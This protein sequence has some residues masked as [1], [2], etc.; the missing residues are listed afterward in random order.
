MSDLDD[1]DL[2]FDEALDLSIL[3]SVGAD[4]GVQAQRMYRQYLTS[5]YVF[6][7]SCLVFEMNNAALRQ[8]CERLGT[9][10]NTIRQALDASSIEFLTDGV[11]VNRDLVKLDGTGF[12]QGEYLYH[13]WKTVGVGEIEATG[14]TGSNDWLE[15]AAAFKACVAGKLT[16]E[17]FQK[18]KFANIRLV[19]MEGA[20]GNEDLAVTDRFRALRAYSITTVA[21]SEL[22]ERARTGA[23]I[24]PVEIKRPVQEMISVCNSCTSLML[25]LVH[26]K[27]HK[28]EVQHHLANTAVLVICSARHLGLSR[29]EMSELAVQAALHGLG[30]AFVA[31]VEHLEPEEAERQYAMESVC[32]LVNTGAT[33]MRTLGRVVV[34]NEVREWA[35]ERKAEDG[36]ALDLCVASR[37]VAVAHAY[38]LLTTP[39]PKRP[40]LMADEAL[41]IIAT[42]SGRRYDAAAVSML[43]NELGVYPVGS[44][45]ALS[46][47]GSAVVVEAPHDKAGPERPK[48][49]MIRDAGGVAFD[50]AILD[51]AGEAGANVHI[52][53]CLDA[54]EEEVNPPAFLLG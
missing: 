7:K 17:Q 48:V 29:P 16:A 15:V 36:H 23:R 22:I 31:D 32:K 37:L 18:T 20:A 50:G 43:I 26:M 51:L 44:V 35:A 52:L 6:V 8:S 30:R 34:A 54:E 27:R 13:V 33:N 3:D 25:A 11:Y 39:R 21:L 46:D 28:V 42:E 24:R 4:D 14:E 41:R 12:E 38:D 49:K 19:P 2:G 5:V 47:G 9:I 1:L 40:A 45:V 10:A 53:H